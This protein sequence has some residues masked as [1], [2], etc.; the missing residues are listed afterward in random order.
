MRKDEDAV[1]DD[2]GRLSPDRAF[3]VQL[4]GPDAVAGRVE[5][6]ASG[7]AAH[8]ECAQELLA[9]LTRGRTREGRSS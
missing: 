4:R 5:H 1:R 8:F 3:V 2:A 9:F 6:M 7:D